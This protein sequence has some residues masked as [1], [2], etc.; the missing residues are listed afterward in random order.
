MHPVAFLRL[1]GL[2]AMCGAGALPVQLEF[3]PAVLRAK[4]MNSRLLGACDFSPLLD[5]LAPVTTTHPLQHLD[6]RSSHCT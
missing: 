4:P 3:K 6:I 2:L 5:V 1:Q